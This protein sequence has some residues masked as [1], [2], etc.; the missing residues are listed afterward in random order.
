VDY[1]FHCDLSQSDYPVMLL[2]YDKWSKEVIR[3]D[4]GWHQCISYYNI[5]AIEVLRFDR[6]RDKSPFGY[7]KVFMGGKTLPI[8]IDRRSSRIV[9]TLVCDRNQDDGY[10]VRTQSPNG[11][12][13]EPRTRSFPPDFIGFFSFCSLDSVILKDKQK[14][15]HTTS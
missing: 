15:L 7:A 5:S 8:T 9:V 3:V 12:I 4:L 10:I 6:L 11:F 13:C 2:C 14:M 1:D